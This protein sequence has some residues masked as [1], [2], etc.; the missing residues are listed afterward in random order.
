MK[1]FVLWCLM[2]WLPLASAH[3]LDPALLELTELAQGEVEILWSMVRGSPGLD[4]IQ[5]TFPAHCTPLTT[6]EVLPIQQRIVLRWRIDCGL[7]GLK[8]QRIA[9]TGLSRRGTDV[10]IRIKLRDDTRHQAVLRGDNPSYVIPQAPTMVSILKGYG[11][12]GFEHILTGFDHLLL[13]LGLTLW[14]ANWRTL[15][16]TISAFTLGHSITLSLAVLGLIRVPAGPVEVLIALSIMT[17]ALGL[18]Q[19]RPRPDR[20]R[21]PGLLALLFGLLHGLGFAG[22]LARIGLPDNEIPLA[23]LSFNLGIELGQILFVTAILLVLLGSRLGSRWIPR[24]WQ[25]LGRGLVAY[26]I[27]SMAAFWVFERATLLF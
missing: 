19:Q 18:T 1:V 16:W 2:T 3:P 20:A 23:L 4:V 21:F 5:P 13:V 10:L 17:V 7:L 15:L 26:G 8:T 11:G 14:V 6:P 22:A 25:D 9:I 12:L 27:G 24:H